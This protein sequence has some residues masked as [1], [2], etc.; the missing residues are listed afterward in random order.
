MYIIEINGKFY[1]S[2]KDYCNEN[3][4]KIENFNEPVKIMKNVKCCS[5]MF[6]DCISFNQPITI[7]DSITS[8][9]GMF[10][11]CRSFNQPI[12][13][14]ESVKNCEDMFD[15]CPSFNSP[16]TLKNTIKACN[17]IL[18]FWPIYDGIITT[19]IS[20]L[21]GFMHTAK[22]K[23]KKNKIIEIETKILKDYN[24]DRVVSFNP[25][26]KY[27]KINETDFAII[28]LINTLN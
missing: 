28:S 11:N 2:I 12:I 13:I 4:I 8:C 26:N 19:P 1:E 16:I 6:L 5:Y 3:N 10:A 24:L 14:P 18:G 21:Y 9:R 7:P 25:N 20:N 27:I 22:F 15:F 17:H 23:Y